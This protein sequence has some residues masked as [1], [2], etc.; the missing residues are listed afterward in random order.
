M[1]IVLRY[2]NDTHQVGFLISRSV[3]NGPRFFSYAIA[4]NLSI[5]LTYIVLSLFWLCG[6]I[7][8][9]YKFTNELTCNLYEHRGS[10]SRRSK[11]TMPNISFVN[12]TR[13]F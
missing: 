2:L 12:D 3:S 9:F 6:L 1:H 13:S 5:N 11:S 8:N 7:C 4:K 10:I